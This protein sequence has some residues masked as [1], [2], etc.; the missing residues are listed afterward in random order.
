DAA[1]VRAP[2]L[3]VGHHAL[4]GIEALGDHAL[5]A[6]RPVHRHRPQ[7]DRI[8]GLH[9]EDVAAVLADL[10][11]AARDRYGVGFHAE[12]ARDIHELAGPQAL[13]GIVEDRLE[14]N[15]PGGGIDLIVEEENLAGDRR[16]GIAGYRR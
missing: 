5:V 1:A 8:I 2:Q 11:R 10:D 14:R 7:L 12:R 16:A 9:H 6:D 3:P 13:V 4:V 15:G